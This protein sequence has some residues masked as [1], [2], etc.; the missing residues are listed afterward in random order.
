MQVRYAKIA[1]VGQ[2]LAPSCAVNGSTGK[3]N[4]HSSDG[5][6]EVVAG[7]RR[8]LFFTADDDKCLLQEASTLRRKQQNSV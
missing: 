2:Y 6:W 3:C 7:K 1:I 4:T 5:P 8:R